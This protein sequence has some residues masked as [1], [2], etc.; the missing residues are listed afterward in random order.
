MEPHLP[1]DKP[2]R[3]KGS[4][5]GEFSGINGMAMNS[6]GTIYVAEGTNNRLQVIS[7]T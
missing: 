4:E 3:E 2:V 7:Y 5:K 6:C 1:D